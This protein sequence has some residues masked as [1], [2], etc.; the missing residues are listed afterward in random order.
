MGD[1]GR[2]VAGFGGEQA[3]GDDFE[4]EFAHGGRGLDLLAVPP[5]GHQRLG[6]A[7]HHAAV[8]GDALAL[9]RG[10][11]QPPL[12]QMNRVFA[13]QQPFAEQAL[14]AFDAGKFLKQ[15]PLRNQQVAD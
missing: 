9:E 11:H 3:A 1:G 12:A 14:G 5:V 10:L 2:L 15:R 7:S 4:R 13:C 6:A 8:L